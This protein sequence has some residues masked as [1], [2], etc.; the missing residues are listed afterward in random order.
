[1]ILWLTLSA[2][3]TLAKDGYYLAALIM[4]LPGLIY[5]YH[6]LEW[7]FEI[8]ERYN[9]SVRAIVDLWKYMLGI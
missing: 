3:I 6:Y 2:S 9:I 7:V 4:V 1:M 8:W 5:T